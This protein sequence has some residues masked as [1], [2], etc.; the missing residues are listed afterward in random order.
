VTDYSKEYE[1]VL[2]SPPL[3]AMT[4]KQTARRPLL[5]PSEKGKK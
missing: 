2:V 1:A 5:K 4:P 3:M